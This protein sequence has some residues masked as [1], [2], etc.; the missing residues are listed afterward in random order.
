MKHC[1][2][3]N[4]L[5]LGELGERFVRRQQPGL[6]AQLANFADEIA[7]NNH[8]VDD[9]IRA[10]LIT[11]E[12]LR[13]VPLFQEFHGEVLAKYPH[14]ADRRLVF[15]ILRRMINRLVTDLIDASAARLRD[16][17]V[18]SMGEVRLHPKPLIG[19]SDT[20][21]D[22]NQA[23]KAFLR[24]HVYRHYKVRRMTAKAG[25]VVGALFDAFF[26]DPGLMPD[27][28]KDTGARLESLQGTAGRARAVADYIAG[29]TDRYAILEHRRLFD[30]GERT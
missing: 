18:A 24:E 28:H 17:G 27:V 6:E 3:N 5:Q 14:L 4:A 20:T 19:F 29:M 7:Y 2:I 25:R 1:S 12:Q 8:D 13:E 15:E 21:R 11:V 22:L 16:S 9:G 23:L 10:G 26:H 30:P